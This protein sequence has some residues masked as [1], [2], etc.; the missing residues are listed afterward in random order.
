[1]PAPH[2]GA[3]AR[4]VDSLIVV[5][6][7]PTVEPLRLRPR[8]RLI[9]ALGYELISS[10]TTAVVELVKNSFDAD[11][12]RVLV[13]FDGPL[14]IG[15]GRL[16][17]ADD[18]HGMDYKTLTTAFLEPATNEKVL[19]RVSP[20]GRRKLGE[21]GIGRFAAG[22]LAERLRVITRASS[23]RT[24]SLLAI[25]WIEFERADY[26]EDVIIEASERMVRLIRD[27][28]MVP[29][30][31]GGPED[32][33]SGTVLEMRR[34]RQAWDIEMLEGLRNALSRLLRPGWHDD[35]RVSMRISGVPGVDHLTGDIT[36]PPFL[37]DPDY[38]LKAEVRPGGRVRLTYESRKT[39]ATSL[40]PTER[41][42]SAAKE[43]GPFRIELRVWDRDPEP[44]GHLASRYGLRRNQIRSAL[45]EAAGV[46]VYRDGFRIL[47][48]GEPDNDWLRLDLRRVQNPTLRVSQNQVVGFIE[49]SGDSNPKLKDQTNREGL[50]ESPALQDLRESVR[51]VLSQLEVKRYPERPRRSRLTLAESF[52]AFQLA[53]LQDF[54]AEHHPGDRELTKA[55]RQEE[56]RLTEAKEQ[57]RR[58]LVRYRR[59][60]ALGRIV[61]IVLHDAS[62][63]LAAI[64]SSVSAAKRALNSTNGSRARVIGHLETI[65]RRRDALAS[66]FNKLRPFTGRG[67][68]KI[69]RISLADAVSDAIALY[70]RQL[71]AASVKLDI[72]GEAELVGAKG[73][74]EQVILNL[75]DNSIYWLSTVAEN[76]RRIAIRVSVDQLGFRQILFSD[77]GPGIP[78]SIQDRIFEPWFTTKP[79]GAGMG[80]DIVGEIAED[81]RGDL[82]LIE[83]NGAG[84]T[85]RVR[86][87]DLEGRT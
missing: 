56:A 38:R 79:D 67:R 81:Y 47:P 78:E 23:A 86:L 34:L 59:W 55:I 66:L 13:R 20:G 49:I 9:H 63:S 25:N 83:S 84:A 32:W 35:F 64:G 22:R 31:M 76:K 27:C 29:D 4:I 10:E 77:T 45:T 40:T 1:M 39:A 14:R 42:P 41:K 61:E 26:L 11:A 69:E 16:T 8:A 68:A 21:K 54:A 24:E 60:A 6:V 5:R 15:G 74:V 72:S 70:K 46:S 80:L 18:G 12:R 44:I 53:A 2:E 51:W 33:S 30:S 62:N 37:D 19:R 73:D 36:P 28:G 87:R 48:Y 3:S 17:I 71:S 7:T 52:D 58:V 57:I 43:C 85:F 65:A 75:L 50:I 82:A